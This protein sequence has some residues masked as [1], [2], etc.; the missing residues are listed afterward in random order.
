MILSRWFPFDGP[1]TELGV[2]YKSQSAQR[3]DNASGRTW[4]SG[5][6]C[7]GGGGTTAG[8]SRRCWRFTWPTRSDMVPKAALQLAHMHLCAGAAGGGM[9]S[10]ALRAGDTGDV[11]ACGCGA[12][13][14]KPKTGEAG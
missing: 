7:G 10:N 8:G 1:G 6:C 5:N 11:W 9:W 12:A 3:H 4:G 14:G 13:W 2:G